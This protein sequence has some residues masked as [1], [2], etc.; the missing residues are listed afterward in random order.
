MGNGWASS[1]SI[2]IVYDVLHMMGRD[3][4]AVGR[5]EFFALNQ[6]YPET[7]GGSAGCKY[8]QAIPGGRGGSLDHD[9]LYGL[10]RDLPRSPRR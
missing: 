4:I 7:F 9:T 10:R 8:R 5:G 2:N 1:S 6:S 3:D